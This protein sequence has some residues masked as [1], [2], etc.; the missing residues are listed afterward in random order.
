MALSLYCARVCRISL[1]RHAGRGRPCMS[2]GPVAECWL[3][4]GVKC[5]IRAPFP[6]MH[7]SSALGGLSL[8]VC[9]WLAPGFDYVVLLSRSAEVDTNSRSAG[10]VLS[11][12]RESYFVVHGGASRHRLLAIATRDHCARPL[13]LYLS[14]SAAGNT[15]SAAADALRRLINTLLPP[16]QPRCFTF[17]RSIIDFDDVTMKMFVNRLDLFY[18]ASSPFASS[19]T[20]SRSYS[21]FNFN[22]LV[23]VVT[24]QLFRDKT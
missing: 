13:W 16:S 2:L 18:D 23:V 20:V 24:R 15:A 10:T 19:S 21:Y 12:R 5:R 7:G 1:F 3:R 6:V 22:S 9:V 11:G 17:A 14:L 8:C 4:L